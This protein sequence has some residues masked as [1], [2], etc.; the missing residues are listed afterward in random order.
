MDLGLKDRV[1]LVTGAGQGMGRGIA[2]ALARE[3][4][5]VA[6][7]DLRGEAA[8][9]VSAEV[10]GLGR[11]SL[12]LCADVSEETQVSAMFK[13]LNERLPPLDILV[14]CAGIGDSGPFAKSQSSDWNRV[15]GVCLY[16]T[17]HSTRAALPRMIERG[18]GR[19]ISIVSDAGRV[20]EP[21][22]VVYSAA[23]AGIIGFTKALAR[24]VGRH[25]IHV[26]CV[27]PGATMT[28]HIQELY[29]RMKQ[30][31]GEAAFEERQKKVLKRYPIGRFGEVEDVASAVCF[32]ASDR[33]S[34]I[35]GQTLSVSGGY[36]MV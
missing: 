3:G 19:I 25:G 22:L 21:G 23:K 11:G 35:T 28:D 10:S 16:G 2:L 26:N 29:A 9:T 30:Q 15:L 8:H 14:N 4:C 1:A 20:G 36:S 17:L 24:E 18:F 5:H 31:M 27:S 34:F 12:A 7:N 33:A 6:I 32:L 13:T